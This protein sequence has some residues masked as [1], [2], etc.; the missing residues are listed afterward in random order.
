[1]LST[2]QGGADVFK[3]YLQKPLIVLWLA[4]VIGRASLDQLLLQRPDSSFLFDLLTLV[5]VLAVPTA[6]AM[7]I[8][9]A[10]RAYSNFPQ[11]VA[12]RAVSVSSK[13]LLLVFFFCLPYALWH[14]RRNAIEVMASVPHGRWIGILGLAAGSGFNLLVSCGIVHSILAAQIRSRQQA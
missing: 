13:F 5:F 3:K 9:R 11:A 8:Y 7:I 10:Y 1:M 12:T 2:M 4:I 14:F 6:E